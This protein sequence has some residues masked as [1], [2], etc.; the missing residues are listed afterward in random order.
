MKRI[1]TLSVR[2]AGVTF[3]NDDERGEYRQ[4]IIYEL[5]EKGL[6]DP[7]DEVRLIPQPENPFDHYA[8]GVFSLDKRQI[9]FL[10]KTDDIGNV[11]AKHVFEKIQEGCIYRAFIQEVH[12]GRGGIG[13]TVNLRIEGYEKD[14]D[15]D[16][17]FDEFITAMNDDVCLQH[18]SIEGLY[19][20]F[21]Y[22]LSF[23][24]D[25]SIL[26][27]LNGYGKTTIF[28]Q[29]ASLLNGDMDRFLNI[30]CKRFT[31]FF[32][33][34]S[35]IT[36]VAGSDAKSNKYNRQME[37]YF[38]DM[39]FIESSLIDGI[40]PFSANEY[41]Y[42]MSDDRIPSVIKFCTGNL[43]A[44]FIRADRIYGHLREKRGN[45]MVEECVELIKEKVDEA[46]EQFSQRNGMLDSNFARR[47]IDVIRNKP[48]Y[49]SI[50]EVNDK[51]RALIERRDKFYYIGLLNTYERHSYERVTNTP[52]SQIK[53]L[54]E[55]EADET[56]LHML[57]VYLKDCQTK[58][59]ILA[60]IYRKILLML[61]IINE[62]HGFA[63]KKLVFNF[64]DANRPVVYFETEN[65]NEIPIS[66]LS[67]GEKNDF[68]IFTELI[69]N[70]RK[71]T[72][73]LIDEPEIS[74]HLAW[75]LKIVDELME[76]AEINNFQ[77]LI[78][79]HAPGI[80]EGHEDK[81]IELG[82]DDVDGE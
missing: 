69:F 37:V 7:N 45:E 21:N 22:E 5:K 76:I 6:L 47:V 53:L 63:R 50:D 28:K 40:M 12:G 11:V 19:D 44:K 38:P 60:P 48:A 24:D 43:S 41:C 66:Q 73:V 74:L 78:A 30:Y 61:R 54:N 36:V 32:S 82:G 62:D 59:D 31:A 1:E 9:G 33:N 15:E 68:I 26:H 64:G 23:F 56:F 13:Y 29:V 20:E 79:T 49:L 14:A 42:Q 16:F 35:K 34:G 25:L 18:I 3:Y 52:D 67:S 70:S 8:V 65:G 72:L 81:M 51:W 46:K 71:D 57:T 77:T 27:A 10:P 80:A 39:R 75:Q 4:N 58:D 2:V 17:D 55:D